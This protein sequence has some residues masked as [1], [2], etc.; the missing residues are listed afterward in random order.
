MVLNRLES[1]DIKN[2]MIFLCDS[3]RWDYTSASIL[4]MGMET[5][6]DN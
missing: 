5:T 6:S 2:I 3:L 4:N 1:Q